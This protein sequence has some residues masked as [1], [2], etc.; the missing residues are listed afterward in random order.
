MKHV[1]IV[2]GTRPEAIK[3]MPVVR[4]LRQA[5]FMRV[6]ILVTGQHR[7]MLDQ[8]FSVF[9]E[10][11]DRD[12][13]LM[14]RNQSLSDI[15]ANVVQRIHE[16]LGELKPSLVL[17]HGD[18][19]TAMASAMAAFYAR[20]RIGHVE[21]GLRSHDL[22]RPWPEEFNRVTIDAIAD[23]LFAPTELARRNLIN[24]YNRGAK[25]L[26]TGNTGIDTLLSVSAIL[27][28][29]AALKNKLNCGMTILMIPVTSFS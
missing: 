1:L 10:K 27:D 18:T 28:Q 21:A 23:Y 6:T 14:T 9:D 13:N 17:V 25:I 16:T 8:V 2:F 3:M 24:E 29:N 26:V 5:Q 20:C 7:E 4:A 15:T 22:Q 11:P 12:L 19:T